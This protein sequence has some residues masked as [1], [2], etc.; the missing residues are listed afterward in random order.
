VKGRVVDITLA[1]T[2]L[3]DDEGYHVH[4]PNMMFMQK[5]FR[6]RPGDVSVPLSE[7]LRKSEPV[8]VAPSPSPAPSQG[9]TTPV[10]TPVARPASEKKATLPVTR[11]DQRRADELPE[12]PEE[13]KFKVT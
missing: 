5:Q 10:A 1:Y 11:S 12:P 8:K 3:Q 13:K 9:P 4:I 6:R 2:V 7:Q